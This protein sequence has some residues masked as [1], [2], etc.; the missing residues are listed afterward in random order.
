MVEALG[1]S[2]YVRYAPQII[3]GLDY[4]TGTVFEAWDKDGEFRAI[5]GGGRYDNLVA[6]VGGDPLPAVGFAMGDLVISLVLK[7]FGCLPPEPGRFAGQ[8]AGD[9]LRPQA[10]RRPRFRLAAGLRQAGINARSTPRRPSWQ[11]SSSTATAWACASPLVLGP[12]EQ[13]QGAGGTQRPAQRRAALRS[14]G[15]MIEACSKQVL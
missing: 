3:R 15:E 13:A 7:K 1:L 11:S 14:A 5:L 10:F 9:S 8:G 12:D 4:Y 2:D 6:D